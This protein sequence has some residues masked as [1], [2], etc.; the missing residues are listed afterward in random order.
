M[1][2]THTHIQNL[3]PPYEIKWKKLRIWNYSNKFRA[4]E[5][6]Y[7][8]FLNCRAICF[9]MS[10]VFCREIFL[11]NQTLCTCFIRYLSNACAV[12]SG[13]TRR[14]RRHAARQ[15]IVHCGATTWNPS[16]SNFKENLWIIYMLWQG[17]SA[18][19]HTLT[20]R[21]IL[22]MPS[23]KRRLK[24]NAANSNT[25]ISNT[26]TIVSMRRIC[27]NL[28]NSPWSERENDTKNKRW[29]KN[30]WSQLLCATHLLKD[31]QAKMGFN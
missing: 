3:C 28:I 23:E 11:H 12:P 9:P 31:K 19:T 18:S 16:G 30:I 1:R 17:T 13:R 22:R 20:F 15:N 5:L 14:K 10:C 7:E 24:W 21:A 6:F 27:D 8:N 29:A 26:K 2:A 4:C 25:S